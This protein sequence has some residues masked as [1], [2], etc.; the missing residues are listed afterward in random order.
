MPIYVK[1]RPMTAKNWI[2]VIAGSALYACSVN[3]LLTPLDL[4]AG[5]F[6][7]LAQLIRS[8]F[9]AHITSMDIAGIINFVFNIPLFLLAWKQLSK[10]MVFGTLLSIAVQTI[11]FTIVPAPAVPLLDDKLACILIAGIL[12]GIGCG[13]VLT[14]GGSAGG[15]DLLGVYVMKEM[16]KVSVGSVSV[17]FNA[18]LY[19]IMAMRFNISTAIYSILFIVAFSLAIDRWHYQ[20]IE[21]QLMI[22]THHP[23]IAPVIMRKYVRGVTGWDG[24]GE[25]TKKD[26][27][28][29]VSIVAKNE[30]EEV[31]RDILK[32][33]PDAF[34]I[35]MEGAQVTGGYDKR[36]V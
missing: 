23:E 9:F 22:F 10:N 19:T 17:I 8:V 20:N 12:G 21:V 25:Y 16:P 33:D 2:L 6:V 15:L 30:V 32:I 36:L 13:I 3:L 34:I 31:K 35:K 7:G 18:V 24:V 27:H 29:L 4:F 5:G 14:N 11:L 26:T 28:V 1:P